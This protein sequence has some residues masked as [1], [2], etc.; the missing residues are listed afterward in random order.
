[1]IIYG[2]NGIIDARKISLNHGNSLCVCCYKLYAIHILAYREM[3][4][5]VIG[6]GGKCCVDILAHIERLPKGNDRLKILEYSHQG[7]GRVATAVV[8]LARLGV[9]TGMVDVVGGCSYGKFCLNDFV[10]NGV[11]I[12]RMIIDE[13]SQNSMSIVLSEKQMHSR[14]ILHH[15]GTTR[16]LTIDD[17]DKEYI[18]YARYV[19]LTN[20]IPA[21]RQAAIW[22]REKGLK[23]IFDAE[24]YSPEIENM[25]P[26]IDVFIASEPFYCSLFQDKNYNINCKVVQDKGPEIVAFTLGEKGCVVLDKNDFHK[27]PSLTVDVYYT[28]G[29]GDVFHG[30]FIYGLLQKWNTWKI[31]RFASAVSAIKCTR[32]GGRAGIPDINTVNKFLGTGQID[33]SDIDKRVEHYRERKSGGY[34]PS[35]LF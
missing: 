20:A 22:A 7:G 21:A 24:K 3:K 19:H 18:T 6:V 35:Q 33:Y 14:A 25:I 11:D 15:P 34:D 9:K 30:A 28:T 26:L 32:I 17:L 31:A 23:V 13:G 5:E 8:T 2:Q 12:S 4:M 10:Y 29:A 27:V 1:V 16:E